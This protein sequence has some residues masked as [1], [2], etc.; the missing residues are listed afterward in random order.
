MCHRSQEASS[1]SSRK[2]GSR[3]DVRRHCTESHHKV[4]TSNLGKGSAVSLTRSQ[5]YYSSVIKCP[6]RPLLLSHTTAM[7]AMVRK[8]AAL[9]MMPS[10]ESAK[11]PRSHGIALLRVTLFFSSILLVL[12]LHTE[13]LAKGQLVHDCKSTPS[14]RNGNVFF[15]VFCLF[16]PK[17]AFFYTIPKSTSLPKSSFLLSSILQN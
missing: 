6:L 11:M 14:L 15:C 8:T 4:Q 7:A 10:L 17:I 3:R 16:S 1:K 13:M 5:Q 2:S 12:C 9:K